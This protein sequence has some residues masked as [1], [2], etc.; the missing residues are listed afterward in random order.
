MERPM[1]HD[2]PSMKVGEEVSALDEKIKAAA[3]KHC[4]I[5]TNSPTHRD[6]VEYARI[7]F[8]R[9]A[10]FMRELMQKETNYDEWI[11]ESTGLK[12][13]R[14]VVN[15][16]DCKKRVETYVKSIKEFQD[17]IDKLR[18]QLAIAVEALGLAHEYHIKMLSAVYGAD[19]SVTQPH[20]FMENRLRVA[21]SKIK[22]GA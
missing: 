20:T 11:T 13:K 6:Q 4:P 14:R 8:R 19:I 15:C 17:E 10:N 7:G 16:P 21:L 3:E 5:L 9:G 2:K 22:G 12:I 18:E 1:T